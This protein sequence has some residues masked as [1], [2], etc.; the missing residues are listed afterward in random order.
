MPAFSPLVPALLS[1]FLP[2]LGQLWQRRFVWACG[3][4]FAF[5]ALSTGRLYWVCIP[6][7]ALASGFETLRVP[8]P[9]LI[10]T[11][12]QN[13]G[14]AF[15]GALGFLCWIGILSSWILSAWAGVP[16]EELKKADYSILLSAPD[17]PSEPGSRCFLLPEVNADLVRVQQRLRV[18]QAVLK[19]ERCYE[20]KDPKFGKGAAVSV[21]LAKEG[22]ASRRVLFDV[23]EE[24]GFT[25]KGRGVFY[26]G[27]W[28]KGQVQ[29]T[30]V[31]DLP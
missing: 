19:V 1:F 29:S 28:K 26:H 15:L 27:L 6:A 2:G 18:L 22:R 16:L 5:V 10:R 20:P 30:A 13:W 4:F 11:R 3:F 7:L 25:A 9:V 8:S 17:R 21:S 31:R 24:V 12:A 23:M 14:Y